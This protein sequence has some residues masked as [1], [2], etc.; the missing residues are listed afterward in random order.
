METNP[1]EPAFAIPNEAAG[2]TKREYFAV[3]MMTGSAFGMP[4]EFTGDGPKYAKEIAENAVR[5]AD[6]LIEALNA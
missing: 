2:L 1:N 3:Q 4:F 5:L 6:A